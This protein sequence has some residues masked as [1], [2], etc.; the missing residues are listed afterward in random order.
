M[1]RIV[2]EAAILRRVVRRGYDNA[3]GE[4]LASPAIVHKDC[5][6]DDRR[7]S[8]AVV[9]LNDGVHVIAGENFE[10]RAL[11]GP[12]KRVR[13]ASHEQRAIGALHAPEVA[14]GLGDG[15]NM[16]FGE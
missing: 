4:T 2:L 10:R 9:L 14:D 5:P 8:H 16:G 15:Q 3:V 11:G 7:R 12:G 13:I 6:R 1:S